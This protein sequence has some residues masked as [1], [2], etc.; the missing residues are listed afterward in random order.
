MGYGCLKWKE[1]NG[2][3]W[4]FGMLLFGVWGWGGTQMAG[5]R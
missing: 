1:N 3:N 4:G 5:H 2:W